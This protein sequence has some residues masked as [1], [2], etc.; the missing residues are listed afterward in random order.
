MQAGGKSPGRAEA[1][2]AR[3][4]KYLL[5]YF[6]KNLMVAEEHVVRKFNHRS[7]AYKHVCEALGVDKDNTQAV[8]QGI[9]RLQTE[10]Q[11]IENGLM[12][13]RRELEQSEPGSASDPI[14][15]QRALEGLQM[16]PKLKAAE[17]AVT[18]ITKSMDE[19][20]VETTRAKADAKAAQATA[21]DAEKR[22]LTCHGRVTGLLEKQEE[23]EGE[24]ERLEDLVEELQTQLRRKKKKRRTLPSTASRSI[25][26]E[27]DRRSSICSVRSQ[28]RDTTRE[29]RYDTAEGESGAEEVRN[30]DEGIERIRRKIEAEYSLDIP[31][32]ASQEYIHAYWE[33]R[34][35]KPDFLDR[36]L[37]LPPWR[38]VKLY[39]STDYM[40]WIRKFPRRPDNMSDQER[41]QI[42]EFKRRYRTQESANV[43]AQAEVHTQQQ[44]KNPQKGR[45]KNKRNQYH[46][47]Q[48]RVSGTNTVPLGDE[49]PQ[50]AG[51]ARVGNDGLVNQQRLVD[52]PAPPPRPQGGGIL[53]RKQIE[54]SLP[55]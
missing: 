11:D 36:C 26:P 34:G 52:H 28:H 35:G 20:W 46:R 55:R 9:S 33:L 16:R 7:K 27:E 51:S 31:L 25:P 53:P 49:G 4:L 24:K 15:L 6:P 43:Q 45:E 42:E 37:G 40:K 44:K 32:T 41:A 3:S 14:I 2:C 48:P 17:E 30:P 50:P 13:L 8:E 18:Q 39:Q 54:F 47:N 21:A 19:A 12:A 29:E 38:A 5:G 1:P 23:L 10:Y 22:A